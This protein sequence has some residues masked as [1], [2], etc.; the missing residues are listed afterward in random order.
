MRWSNSDPLWD[1]SAV[2]SGLTPV[3]LPLL[4]PFCRDLLL[5]AEGGALLLFRAVEVT[6]PFE[7]LLVCP[8]D[9]ELA[10]AFPDDR[11]PLRQSSGTIHE[12]SAGGFF[13]RLL[14][15]ISTQG[16]SKS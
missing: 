5:V 16:A 6:G 14:S 12:D 8:A 7:P 15:S 11:W 2:P 9:G 10:A 13:G 1:C 4:E 3:A